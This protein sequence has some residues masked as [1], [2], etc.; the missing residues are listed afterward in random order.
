MPGNLYFGCGSA[1]NEAPLWRAMLQR[2]RTKI[3]YW[4]FALPPQMR[5]SADAWLRGN[6]D[7]LGVSYELQTWQSLD[8]HDATEL[9]GE[10]IDLLFVGGG[11]TFRLLDTVQRHGFT[12]PVRRFWRAGGDYYGGSAGAVLACQSIAIAEGLDDNEPGLDD[13]TGLGLVQGAVI[14]PHFTDEQLADAERWSARHRMVVLGLPESVGLHCSDETATVL[15][16]GH[17]TRIMPNTVESI[18]VGETVDLA[19]GSAFRARPAH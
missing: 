4:P 13:L 16:E 7:T 18:A 19:D 17:L 14:L 12:E 9:N 11:N 1:E 15:G 3:V 2:D 10:K 6:L 8:Q 5:P